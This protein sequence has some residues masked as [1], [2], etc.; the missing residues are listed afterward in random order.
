VILDRCDKSTDRASQLSLGAK[1]ICN[2]LDRTIKE[3]KATIKS[4]QSAVSHFDKTC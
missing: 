4:Y 1:E 3:S 2:K